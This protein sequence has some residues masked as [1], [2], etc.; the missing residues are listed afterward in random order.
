MR[1]ISAYSRRHGRRPG[2]RVGGTPLA[3][4]RL[5]RWFSFVR[6]PQGLTPYPAIRSI[7]SMRLRMNC[8]GRFTLRLSPDREERPGNSFL[9]VPHGRG[10]RPV[11]ILIW[12]VLLS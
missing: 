4:A 3:P 2:E 9:A 6:R 1:R 7:G 12:L 8:I 10:S 11:L 5:L